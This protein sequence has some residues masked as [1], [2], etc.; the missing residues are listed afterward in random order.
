MLKVAD[1]WC[2]NPSRWLDMTIKFHTWDKVGF[3]LCSQC[4]ATHECVLGEYT[5]SE[6]ADPGF[7]DRFMEV[8]NSDRTRAI[9][10][11]WHE[12]GALPRMCRSCPRLLAESDPP[13]RRADVSDDWL[14]TLMN[15]GSTHTDPRV[16]SL[17][18]DPS[19]NL[20]CPSCRPAAFR[21]R[22][23][24]ERYDHLKVFQR[25]FVFRLA[26]DA[27]DIHCTGYGDP[28][29]SNLYWELLTTITPDFAPRLKWYFLTNGL[30]FTPEAYEAIPT[31]AQIA[32]VNVS[33]DAATEDTYRALRGG[34]W[35]RLQDNLRFLSTLR[36]DKFE[37]G[38][39]VQSANWR[40]LPAFMDSAE[41]LG[42]TRV[43]LY[44]LLNHAWGPE[45]YALRAIHSPNH[46][47]HGDAMETIRAAM[48]STKVP[49]Y[50][51]AENKER[52]GVKDAP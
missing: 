25:N 20:A 51:E 12:R 42:A 27:T 26:A 6:M 38:F 52:A 47:D 49:C 22:P 11:Q 40:E 39:V 32:G 29:G 16:L 41:R 23:G 4:W 1:W 15:N 46:P 34:S 2:P 33:V 45:Q 28:F 3:A 5:L 48:E 30:G 8:W 35:S 31:R 7:Y 13:M 24:D 19:C 44:T 9:R 21:L 10:A 14:S 36:L 37:L 43:L 50:W 17:G 18:Y